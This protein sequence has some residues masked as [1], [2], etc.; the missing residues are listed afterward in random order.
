ML[1]AILA[2]QQA[3]SH[4]P[5]IGPHPPLPPPTIAETINF[6]TAGKWG[7]GAMPAAAA[8]FKVQR[9]ADNLVNPRWLYVL[10]SGDILVAE[11]STKPK[12]PK[13]EKDKQK[14]AL[15]RKAGNIA[16]N[17]DR[18][19]LLR[20]GDKDGVAETRMVFR[21]N[22]NQPFG[23]LLLRD[24]FYVANTDG[25]MMFPYKTGQTRLEGAGKKILDLPAGG[26]NNHW[27][28][29]L[30]A[31]AAGSRIYVTVGSASNVGEHGMPEEHRRANILEINPDGSG[32]RIFA[33]GLRNPNGMD[34]QPGTGVLWTAVNERDNLG[35]DLVPDYL[36]GVREGG[37][38]GWPYSY[39]GKNIDSRVQ[40]QRPDLVSKAIVPDFALGPHTASL[41]LT[42]YKGGAFPQ[43][44][45][46]GAFIA[47]HGSWNRAQFSGYKVVFVPFRNGRPATPV[48]DF[49]TGFLADPKNG[50]TNGRPVGVAVDTS[51]ALL[52]ADDTGNTVWR[53][54][55]SK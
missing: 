50:R 51:G 41:G 10:P 48:E 36:T 18:I 55:P 39:F 21:E 31:N 29:N 28:R 4:L 53:V 14:Q 44:Y 23:M 16:V 34:W 25:V 3:S 49:L 9:F 7:A 54:S 47:Q 52:V 17:A 8:G 27:T 24:Q 1:A 35:E 43:R 30:I 13:T 42:F 19:T 46:G 5:G 22:L 26:Y 38:Y 11:A 37:F 6:S 32:E 40:E 20:D 33:S 2:G 12:P 15:L 45:H